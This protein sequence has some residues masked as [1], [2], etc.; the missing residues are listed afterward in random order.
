VC[1]SYLT[2][3]GSGGDGGRIVRFAEHRDDGV[4][5]RPTGR[6][7]ARSHSEVGTGTADAEPWG[8]GAAEVDPGAA[9]FSVH[10]LP[11]RRHLSSVHRPPFAERLPFDHPITFEKARA[12]RTVRVA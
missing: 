10:R 1:W 3:A 6:V 5:H 8:V 9:A 11:S 2:G 7:E 4:D 12:R